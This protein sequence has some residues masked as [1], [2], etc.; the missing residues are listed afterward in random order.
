[1]VNSESHSSNDQ[2]PPSTT[3]SSPHEDGCKEADNKLIECALTLPTMKEITTKAAT[4]V[5]KTA[6]LAEDKFADYMKGGA[7]NESF[8]ALAECPDRDKPDKQIAMLKC[9]EAHSD[10]YHKYN[11]IIDEQVLKE[12]KSIFPGGDLGF[13]LGVHEFLTK[14]EGGC[15]KEQYLACMDCHIEEGLKEEEEELGPGFI[16]FAKRLIRF[17]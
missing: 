2:V 16:T 5:F 12:A 1:M 3:C 9:M 11:E 7:C 14:G 15:C 6:D 17:L 4:A 8:M 10:Y 13:L